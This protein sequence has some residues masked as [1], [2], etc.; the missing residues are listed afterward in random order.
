MAEHLFYDQG[1]EASSDI[2][3]FESI[4]PS[5][6]SETVPF[7]GAGTRSS[8]WPM[9]RSISYDVNSDYL[10]EEN[11]NEADD[12]TQHAEPEDSDPATI[13]PCECDRVTSF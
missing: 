7:F 2:A 5:P 8:T 1:L 6:L 13:K 9:L 12:Q 10:E 4:K 3:E 11:D